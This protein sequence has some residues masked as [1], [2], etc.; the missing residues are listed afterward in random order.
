MS[1]NVIEFS[2]FSGVRTRIGHSIRTG[3]TAFKQLGNLHAE[4][5]LPATSI[6]VDA[7]KAKFQKELIGAML[8]E[9]AEVILDPKTVELSE[10]GRF[11]GSA[12]GAPWA[13]REDDRQLTPSDFDGLSAIDL[14]GQIARFAIEIGA[15]AV[16]SPSHFLRNGASDPLLVVDRSAVFSLRNALDKEGGHHIAIDYALVLPHTKFNDVAHR[17]RI[18][19][20]LTGLPID[21][22]IVRLSGFGSSSGPLTAKQTLLSLADMQSL[23]YPISLDHI[24]GLIATAA[25]AFGFVS[26]ISHGI[27]ERE[28]FDARDWHKPPKERDPDTPFGRAVFIPVPSFDRAYRTKDLEAILNAQG[29]RRLISCQ[30]RT[31]CPKGLASTLDKPKAH[32]A[33]QRF[34]TMNALFETPDSRRIQ[35]FLDTDMRAAERKAGDLARLKIADDRISKSLI[36]G[37]K[38][39]DHFARTFETLSQVDR[40]DAPTVHVRPS[41]NLLSGVGAI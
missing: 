36:E 32:M 6:I 37:R 2:N 40:R 4:G 20:S 34:K 29:G 30:D 9:G 1:T 13:Q 35:H 33:R 16:M 24:G 23:G 17:E 27:G 14:Y 31:C 22:L 5:R 41:R 12:S 7:S 26:G 19:S 18:K 11:R 28:R 3:E 39:I 21:N 15:T 8:G 38:R 10:V 25:V